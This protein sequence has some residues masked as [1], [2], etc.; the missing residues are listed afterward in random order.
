MNTVVLDKTGTLTAGRPGLTDIVPAPGVDPDTLLR[1]AAGAEKGSEHPLSQAIVRHAL[2]RKLALQP[3]ASFNALAGQGVE[4]MVEGHAVLLG[5]AGLLRGRNI[6]LGNLETQAEALAKDSKTPVFVAVDG[7]AAGVLAVADPLR[8]NSR[9]A[10]QRLK[11]LGLEVIMLT[12][13]SEGTAR[14]IARQA[15][16]DRYLA[17]VLPAHKAD[18]IKKLQQQGKSVA[19][20]GDGINDAP[21]LAQADVGLAIGSGTDVAIE[22]AGITILSNDVGGVVNAILLA[23]RTMRTIK[24]NLFF[25]FAYN[26]LLIPAAAGAFFPLLGWLVNPML[27][28][29]AMVLSDVSVVG[30]SL[31]L[32]TVRFE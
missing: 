21:A 24:Q 7:Q 4:A 29:L 26:V 9:H 32:R 8:E 1:L 2:E 14:A 17:E 31:R 12:G 6:A 19:M 16:I 10:V 11:E 20:V 23:R 28:S 5:N 3:H 30:N 27:A 18:E 25:S 13:D 22:A 15:G